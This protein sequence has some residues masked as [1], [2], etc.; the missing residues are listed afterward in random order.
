MKSNASLVAE[1]DA[2]LAAVKSGSQEAE[3]LT[4]QLRQRL[5]RLDAGQAQA[6]ATRRSAGD[7]T[8]DSFRVAAMACFN[9]A[10]DNPSLDYES[11]RRHWPKG[12]VMPG[13]SQINRL[14]MKW[15]MGNDPDWPGPVSLD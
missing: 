13:K 11:L 4:A 12:S 15:L 9:E 10:T 7:I 2:L 1:L 14:I 6:K 8:R 3:A 5:Q